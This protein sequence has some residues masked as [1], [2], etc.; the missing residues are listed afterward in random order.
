[1]E[2]FEEVGFLPKHY[3]P[4]IPLVALMHVLTAFAIISAVI[5]PYENQ[6]EIAAGPIQQ[7]DH[8]DEARAS[9]S[10]N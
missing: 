5:A 1:M 4:W 6:P 7:S 10:L 3:I 2:S 8:V 9:Q